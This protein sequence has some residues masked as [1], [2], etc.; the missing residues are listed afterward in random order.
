[1]K[2]PIQK[3]LI[4]LVTFRIS[5]CC[6]FCRKHLKNQ[7]T[8]LMILIVLMDFYL[9]LRLI[10]ELSTERRRQIDGVEQKIHQEASY[11]LEFNTLWMKSTAFKSNQ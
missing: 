3:F 10:C 8:N 2:I 11:F 9:N 4:L 5:V 7:I 1:M 6:L